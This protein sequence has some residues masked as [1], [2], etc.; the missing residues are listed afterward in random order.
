MLLNRA[1][2][3]TTVKKIHGRVNAHF[4]IGTERQATALNQFFY[5]FVDAERSQHVV[6]GVLSRRRFSIAKAQPRNIL[7]VNLLDHRGQAVM[8]AIA[9]LTAEAQTTKIQE[10][11]IQGYQNLA[12]LNPQSLL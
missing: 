9:A 10:K 5:C 1:I 2:I 3:S 12:R 11:I 4:H 8:T 6:D 7:S